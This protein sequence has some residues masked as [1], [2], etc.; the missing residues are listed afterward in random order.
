[1]ATS[2]P[3]PSP[4]AV[5][6][7]VYCTLCQ[8]TDPLAQAASLHRLCFCLVLLFLLHFSPQVIPSPMFQ[9][10]SLLSASISLCLTHIL[11]NLLPLGLFNNCMWKSKFLTNIITFLHAFR[12]NLPK[13]ST[14]HPCKFIFPQHKYCSIYST[15][16]QVRA[17]KL[18]QCV[19]CSVCTLLEL[20]LGM[21]SEHKMKLA[22][23]LLQVNYLGKKMFKYF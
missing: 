21:F 3:S 4:E 8:W 14:K 18:H 22:N 5:I 9:K 11:V 12:F 15:L 17:Q 23:Q 16:A 6:Q 13:D 10:L 20:T 2:G 19:H 7:R 1:M